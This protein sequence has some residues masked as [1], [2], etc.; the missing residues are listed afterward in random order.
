MNTLTIHPALR[1][2]SKTIVQ[3]ETPEEMDKH[4]IV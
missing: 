4:G 3:S 2:A 1:E